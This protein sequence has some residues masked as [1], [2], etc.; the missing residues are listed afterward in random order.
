MSATQHGWGFQE[1]LALVNDPLSRLGTQFS[2]RDGK[3]AKSRKTIQHGLEDIWDK[4]VATVNGLDPSFTR[5]QVADAAQA[6]AEGVMQL[7]ADPDAE[8]TDSQRSVLAY[9][10]EQT[11]KRGMLRVAL[12]WRAVQEATCL[13]ERATKNAMAHLTDK[14]LLSLE[15]SGRS[16]ADA[17]RWKANLYSL[18]TKEA[19]V[20]YRGRGTRPMGPPSTTSGTPKEFINGTSATTYGPPTPER[21]TDTISK[22]P[23]VVRLIHCPD[24]QILL[25]AN[26]AEVMAVLALEKGVAQ[27]QITE[28]TQ[29]VVRDNV[30]PIRSAR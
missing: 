6:R 16:G 20:S 11:I 29:D 27:L 13:G 30:T 14:N 22:E 24:G 12:A 8:L 5:E 4:A 2:L 28:S 21:S 15:A 9:A 18:P 10:A 1:W 17:S 19:L 25:D 26:D 7:V 3:R 23:T